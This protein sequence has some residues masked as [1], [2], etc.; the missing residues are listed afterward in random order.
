MLSAQAKVSQAEARLIQAKQNLNRVKPHA[1][2]RS[3]DMGS[4]R[5][6]APGVTS[7]VSVSLRLRARSPL[8]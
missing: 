8:M 1:A 6:A 4:P 3:N 5:L 7:V 2:R